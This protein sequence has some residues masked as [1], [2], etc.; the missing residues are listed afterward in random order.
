MI[1]VPEREIQV[2]KKTISPLLLQAGR[3]TIKSSEDINKSSEFLKK[4]R[5]AERQIE[6]KRLEFTKP[7]NQS[8]KAIN[9]MFRQFKEPLFRARML[10]TGKILDWKK[11]ETAR[12]EKEEARRRK[13]QEAH[14][15][16]GH[17]VKA[18][19]VLERPE[20]KIG[21]VQT[22]KVWKWDVTSFPELSDHY[23]SVNNV[24]INQAIRAGVHAIKGLKIYQEEKLSVVSRKAEGGEK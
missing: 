3:Y 12:L 9:E 16:Q 8:L 18:P 17:E 24:L 6:A 20:G 15:K 23:K 14:K 7:L 13:I 11:A 1:K 5:D 10:L 19:V 2:I 22:R 21:N 4:L